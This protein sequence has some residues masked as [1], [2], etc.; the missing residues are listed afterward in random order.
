MVTWSELLLGIR[1]GLCAAFNTFLQSDT[2]SNSQTST[3]H[4]VV[5]KDHSFMSC[6]SF[7]GVSTCWQWGTYTNKN[8]E[9]EGGLSYALC[10][11]LN[12]SVKLPSYSV[13]CSV[14]G[15]QKGMLTNWLGTR[16]WLSQ[17]ADRLIKHKRF[18]EISL[19][20]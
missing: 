4:N 20:T 12:K 14:K 18:G 10:V 3:C 8:M 17:S 11:S 7:K 19:F 1:A 2:T 5:N 13:G 15:P 16:A 6:E 9:R